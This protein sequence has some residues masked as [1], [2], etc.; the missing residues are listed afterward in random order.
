MGCQPTE[1]PKNV[2]IPAIRE[3]YYRE[4]D[5]RVVREATHQYV[6][7]GHHGDVFAEMY[8]S[9]PYTPVAPREA[10][11][12][13]IDVAVMGGGWT[14]ILAGYHLMKQGI[15]DF[16][17]IDHAGGFGGVWYWNRYPGLQCDNDAYCYLPLLEETGF[18]PSKKFADGREILDYAQSIPRHFGYADKGLFHT[19]VTSLTWDETASRWHILTD[20]GDDIRARF[21]IMAN[22]LLNIP[23]L[24]GIPG[25]GNFKGKMFHTSRWDYA[26]TGGE[27]TNPVLDKLADKRVAIIGTGATSVQAVPFL[28]QYAKQLYVLQRTPS[29]VDKRA[30]QATD[31]EWVKSLKPGWQAERQANFHRAAMEMFRPGEPDLICD[32]WTEISRNLAAELEAEGWPQLSPDEFMKRREV[33]DYQVMER[34]RARVD[35][36]VE[37]RET[38]EKLKP[39]YRYLCKRPAS[40]DDYYPTFNRPNV[41]LID[42]SATRGV[43]AMTEKGFIA[44][45]RE[46]EIDCMIF[47]SGFEVTSDLDR[48][49]GIDVIEGRDGVSIYDHWRDGYKSLH[50]MTTRGFPNMFFTGYVQSA[51]NS[52]T[53]EQM[54][55]HGEHVAY[56]IAEAMR[57]GATVV[58]PTAEAEA[59]W[60]KHIRETAIDIWR[61]QAECTPS[62]FNG[63]GSDKKRFYAGEAYGPGWDA[64]MTLLTGWRE[65]GDLAGLDLTVSA[66]RSAEPA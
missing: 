28:G 16:R 41:K 12:Q 63:E 18:M 6:T 4:R 17:I 22:G 48:R 31:P 23:K 33:V 53:T 46:Y 35:S 58:E 60:V 34:L 13:E 64:F 57:R 3:K 14:G 2:D 38:A 7:T 47:A 52:S 10:L 66:E 20:R 62:Y 61:F 65:A 50:G 27:Q 42:V 29:T 55:R 59:A 5:K 26:Y 30:N 36:L 45:G 8:E 1:T 19:M 51:L 43:E 15:T 54:S 11:E 39:W 40:N 24:P 21:V 25:I 37:D 44:D 9:D 49:W 32:I 56:I